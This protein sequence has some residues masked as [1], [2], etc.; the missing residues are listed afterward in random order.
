MNYSI[1]E[2]TELFYLFLLPF[3]RISSFFIVA[4][5]F[6][7]EA[8]NARIRIAISFVITLLAINLVDFNPSSLSMSGLSSQILIQILI[9]TFSGFLFVII[10]GALTI[11]GQAISNSLGLGMANMVDPSLGSVPLL[12]QFF[13]ILSTL[14]FITINGHLVIT[15]IILQSFSI[16]PLG[17]TIEVN[18]IYGYLIEWTPLLFLGGLVIALP[19]LISVLL[20][21][22]GLG[23]ITRS[24]PSLNIISVGF[25]II[26]MI[27][28]LIMLL[29]IPSMVSRIIMFWEDS[30]ETVAQLMES[31]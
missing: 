28:F 22:F 3:A 17:A 31:L 11:A 7:L 27:G 9:G 20:I 10:N 26:I 25:P 13:I 4:P 21:N 16:I 18:I 8:V 24:A 12:S 29:A 5:F 19:V 1:N 30:F 23:M 2:I 6:A 15:N 14:I